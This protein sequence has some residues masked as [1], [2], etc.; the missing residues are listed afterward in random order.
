MHFQ[1]LKN[2]VSKIS[3]GD[4]LIGFDFS[5]RKLLSNGL[6]NADLRCALL[7]RFIASTADMK[8]LLPIDVVGRLI[9]A[10]FVVCKAKRAN[11]RWIDRVDV[12]NY[13]S[14]SEV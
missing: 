9:L 1:Q 10:E 12:I 7:G 13:L 4:Q 5:P 3:A 6:S 8:L 11:L 14:N 2:L